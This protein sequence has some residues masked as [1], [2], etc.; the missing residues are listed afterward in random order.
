MESTAKPNRYECVIDMAKLVAE[1]KE[2]I[3]LHIPSTMFTR[4]CNGTTDPK[5][6]HL[7]LGRKR[8]EAVS[9]GGISSTKNQS[10]AGSFT[11]RYPQQPT[12]PP[13][14]T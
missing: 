5:V 10:L 8:R 11:I 7:F 3:V 13:P 14:A 6:T 12:G 4:P 1:G 2:Q 9:E